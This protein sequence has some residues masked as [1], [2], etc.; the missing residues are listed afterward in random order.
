MAWLAVATANTQHQETHD[1]ASSYKGKGTSYDTHARST[2][3]KYAAKIQ[4]LGCLC[5]ALLALG[6]DSCC[7]PKPKSS[8]DRKRCSGKQSAA[9]K[10]PMKSGNS[11]CA[12]GTPLPKSSPTVQV[13]GKA[14]ACS[15]THDEKDDCCSKAGVWTAKSA[16]LQSPV[17]QLA[18][19]RDVEQGLP[20]LER[21]ILSV[22]GMTCTGCETSL[23]R[24]LAGL[25]VKNLRTSLVQS[26][27]EF[28]LD[29]ASVPVVCHFIFHFRPFP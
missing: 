12:S 2:R 1:S 24:T 27:A 3:E 29:L 16:E 17:G 10:K 18:Q 21:V 22:S 15:S 9:S 5:R 4:A 25:E 28:D 13:R 6:Q 26:K 8:L 7:P 14:K 19:S 23:K 20:G 11:C